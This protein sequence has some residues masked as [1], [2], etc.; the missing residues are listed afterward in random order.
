MDNSETRL[1][2]LPTTSIMDRVNDM[3]KRT[4]RRPPQNIAE[5][6]AASVAKG[7]DR[8]ILEQV[9]KTLPR[10]LT[11]LISLSLRDEGN[12]LIEETRLINNRYLGSTIKTLQAQL[13][14]DLE[15]I[16]LRDQVL[17]WNER[18]VNAVL[19]KMRRQITA[20][21]IKTYAKLFT[22]FVHELDTTI[23]HGTN[24]FYSLIWDAATEALPYG[25]LDGIFFKT[26]LISGVYKDI[27][28]NGEREFFL[29]GSLKCSYE[30]RHF[31]GEHLTLYGFAPTVYAQEVVLQPLLQALKA[32]LGSVSKAEQQ[33]MCGVFLADLLEA[34]PYLLSSTRIGKSIFPVEGSRAVAAFDYTCRDGFGCFFLSDSASCFEREMAFGKALG[35]LEVLFDGK[36][37][38][39][40]YPRMTLEA[41][42]GE[43]DGLLLTYWFLKQARERVLASY[44]KINSAYLARAAGAAKESNPNDEDASDNDYSE[45]TAWVRE[46]QETVRGASPE[47]NERIEAQE[48]AQIPQMRRSRLFKLLSLCGVTIAQGKGSEIKLLRDSTHPFRLG[49]HYGPNPTV[50]SFLIANILKRLEISRLEWRQ[51]IACAGYE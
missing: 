12:A 22:S 21:P 34:F 25:L 23:A 7:N 48:A 14:G 39:Y 13:V 50:P 20:D 46:A 32:D 44:L 51:A 35:I 27:G 8:V 41:V 38:F 18:V 28:P 31:I 49:N 10:S 3:E 9:V 43:D 17:D 45:Y 36:I 6:Y 26:G 11:E 15:V 47:E 30:E 16:E 5:A 40:P 29:S 4:L 37:A 42:F 19:F 1:M 24:D 2:K 33:R